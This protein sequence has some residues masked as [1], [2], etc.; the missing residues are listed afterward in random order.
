MRHKIKLRRLIGLSTKLSNSY[1]YV[2]QRKKNI[3]PKENIGNVKTKI[4]PK[5]HATGMAKN[6]MKSFSIARDNAP[7]GLTGSC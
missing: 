5:I 6:L 2:I 7:C 3:S 4:Q 1:Y